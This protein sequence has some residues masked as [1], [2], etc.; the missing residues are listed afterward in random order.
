MPLRRTATL[1]HLPGAG[2]REACCHSLWRVSLY[3]SALS[4]FGIHEP[5]KV[6]NS[7][8]RKGVI[9]VRVHK[10]K[11]WSPSAIPLPRSQN[12][13]PAGTSTTHRH[14]NLSS[15]SRVSYQR[16]LL[17]LGAELSWNDFPYLS[18]TTPRRS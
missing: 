17:G 15:Y 12:L 4:R 10:R 8:T 6:L 7:K 2:L 11:A 14:G 3:L 1:V 5:A 13:T 16:A 9:D 18:H